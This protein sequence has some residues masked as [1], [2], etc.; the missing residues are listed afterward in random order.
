MPGP[1]DIVVI[2]SGHT[3]SVGQDITVKRVQVEGGGE[4]SLLG[5]YKVTTS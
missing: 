1:N 2:N 3:V 4:L 5:N